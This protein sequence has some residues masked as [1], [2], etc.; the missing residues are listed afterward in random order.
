MAQNLL[1]DLCRISFGDDDVNLKREKDA[2]DK[3]IEEILIHIQ[4]NWSYFIKKSFRKISKGHDGYLRNQFQSFTLEKFYSESNLDEIMLLYGK[5]R[6]RRL[7]Y[8]NF[9]YRWKKMD[10]KA[11]HVFNSFLRNLELENPIGYKVDNFWRTLD[12]NEKHSV[13]Y[14]SLIHI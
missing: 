13:A 5:K 10:A 12:E 8:K 14:L 7:T 9:Y 11:I 3:H 6:N 1:V 4:S 2:V